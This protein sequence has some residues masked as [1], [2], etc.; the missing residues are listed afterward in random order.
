MRG[1]VFALPAREADH[2]NEVPIVDPPGIESLCEQ[3]ELSAAAL[4]IPRAQNCAT[5]AGPSFP[6]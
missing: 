3:L 5:R 4:R 6:G 1:D 2:L